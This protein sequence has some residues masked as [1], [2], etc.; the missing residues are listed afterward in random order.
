MK[1]S[2]KNQLLFFDT[3]GRSVCLKNPGIVYN[4]CKEKKAEGV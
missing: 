4:K 3:C 2:V 1:P